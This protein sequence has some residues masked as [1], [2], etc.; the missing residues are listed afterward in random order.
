[1]NILAIDIGGTAIKYGIVNG[2][3]EITEFHEIDSNAKLGAEHIVN[4]VLKITDGYVGAVDAVGIS[5]AGQVDSDEGKILYAN[6]N[7]PDYIG[8]DFSKIIS[9]KYNLPVSVE[10]DVN[11]AAV[12]EAVYGAGRG[13]KDFICLTYGTGVGG[14]IWLDGGLYRGSRYSAGEFGNI[15]THAGGRECAC[16]NKGCYEMYASTKALI[17]DVYEK[18]KLNLNGRQI[19]SDQYF[20]NPEIKDVIDHWINEIVIGL[21][22]LIFIFNPPLIILG[23]GIMNEK[24]IVDT[25]KEKIASKDFHSFK[26]VEIKNAML[27]NKAGMLGAAHLAKLKLQ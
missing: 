16:G 23:G 7:I 12:G 3:A 26:S 14:A 17:A 15:I 13:Y 1:M 27:G 2:N 22:G 21:T 5:T 25:I 4:T 9:N 6:K 8:T 18:T 19:F 20:S 11:C 10:N 24:Y